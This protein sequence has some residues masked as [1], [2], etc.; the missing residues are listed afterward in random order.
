KSAERAL[1]FE[2]ALSYQ[3]DRF[4]QSPLT[5]ED[6]Q[7]TRDP[8]GGFMLAPLDFV[9]DFDT[10]PLDEE[11]LNN[12]RRNTQGSRRTPY[13][14]ANLNQYALVDLYRNNA[15]GVLGFSEDGGPT[16][17]LFMNKEDRY[18]AKAAL[19][20]QFDRYNRLKIGGEYTKYDMYSY[21]HTLNSQAF[22]DVWNEEPIRYNAFVEDRLDLGDVVVVGGLRYDFYDSKAERPYL[23]ETDAGNPN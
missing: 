10:F 21:S 18:I 15:H 12:Y 20:W 1:A 7:S 23:C 4:L 9:Y 6:E 3:T 19:D 17:R 5:S 11:L 22:S 14:L 16:G 2:A 8:F 13:D